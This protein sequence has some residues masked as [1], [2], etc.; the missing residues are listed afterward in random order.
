MKHSEKKRNFQEI[1]LLT[2]SFLPS[3]L[4]ETTRFPGAEAHSMKSR[5]LFLSEKSVPALTF[6][7][8]RKDSRFR[9]LH[10]D[11][12]SLEEVT[13]YAIIEANPTADLSNYLKSHRFT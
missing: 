11:V 12:S 7:R 1:P 3:N 13:K 10:A 4:S 9:N 2:A 6:Q 8:S 5:A